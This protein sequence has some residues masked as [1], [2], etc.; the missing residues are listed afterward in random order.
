V[1][2]RFSTNTFP[3]AARPPL[4]LHLPQREI[5]TVRGNAAWMHARQ[6][7]LESPLFGKDIK[8]LLP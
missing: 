7:I 4:P 2:Q 6:P 3:L 5:N 8:K 1:H